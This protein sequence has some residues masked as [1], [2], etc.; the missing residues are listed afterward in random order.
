[1]IA[2]AHADIEFHAG[3]VDD[4]VET[5]IVFTAEHRSVRLGRPGGVDAQ[6]RVDGSLKICAAHVEE[7]GNGAGEF[8]RLGLERLAGFEHR[9]RFFLA[10]TVL[11]R[12]L[13]VAAP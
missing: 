6:Y 8:E 5:E 12:F 4:V 11:D 3:L 9:L 1:M 10:R 7:I 13:T 2:L